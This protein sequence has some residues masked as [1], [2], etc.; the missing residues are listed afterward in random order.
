LVAGLDEGSAPAAPAPYQPAEVDRS[1]IHVIT[2]A[3]KRAREYAKAVSE[4]KVGVD[5]ART[6]LIARMVSLTAAEKALGAALPGF[7]EV[8]VADNPL[9]ERSFRDA[10]TAAAAAVVAAQA[11]GGS[12]NP[13]LVAYATAVGALRA[14][15]E[16]AASEKKNSSTTPSTRPRTTTPA[17]TPAPTPTPEPVPTDPPSTTP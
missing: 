7:A 3:A 17:P 5:S 14:D 11:A 13:E 4:A 9:A 6:E 15:Q 10:V 16:R 1:D 8:V 12:G 2:A